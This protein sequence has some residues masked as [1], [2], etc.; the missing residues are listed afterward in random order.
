MSVPKCYR[1]DPN[2]SSNFCLFAGM[3]IH[4]LKSAVACANLRHPFSGSVRNSSIDIPTPADSRDRTS[5]VGLRKRRASSS[6]CAIL[7]ALKQK[8]LNDTP[9]ARARRSTY[10]RRFSLSSGRGCS[11]QA[12][13]DITTEAL[14]PSSVAYKLEPEKSIPSNRIPRCAP[15][16]ASTHDRS[17]A[18]EVRAF[19]L[20]GPLNAPRLPCAKQADRGRSIL[21]VG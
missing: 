7:S 16:P 10:W 2:L 17:R 5:P 14:D 21:E 19:H 9:Y 12:G 13:S 3:A 8:V 15:G 11:G 4:S 20:S 18:K 6:S 1:P